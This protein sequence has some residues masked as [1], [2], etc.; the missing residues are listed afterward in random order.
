[1]EFEILG[2]QLPV[3]VCKMKKGEKMVSESGGMSWMTTGMAMQT[4][5]KGGL[6]GALTRGISGESAFVNTFESTGENDEIAFAS[7][8]PGQ[9]V[10]MKLEEGQYIIA[11][12]GAFLAGSENVKLE[13]YFRKK[14]W[15]GMFGGEGF[16]LNKISGPGDIF[17]EIDGSLIEKTLA[18]GEMLKIDTGYCA[19]LEPTITFDVQMLKGFKKIFFGGDGLFLAVVTGP[20]KIWIQTLTVAELAKDIIPFIPTKSS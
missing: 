5:M 14:F 7:S 15:A 18:P 11:Q 2:N 12:R 3:V 17:L 1:M 6:L 9:I 13:V 10:H 4:T 20:G 19:I 16:V 8:F